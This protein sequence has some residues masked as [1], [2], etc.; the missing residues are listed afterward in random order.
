MD[1]HLYKLLHLYL[2]L[3]SVDYVTQ[4]L[5]IIIKRKDMIKK[6]NILVLQT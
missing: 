5:S 1:E 6:I 3:H 2:K 4:F